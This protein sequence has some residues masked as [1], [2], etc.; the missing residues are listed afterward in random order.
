MANARLIH[1]VAHRGN[2]R[3]CPENTL[4][5][6]RS[7][8]ELGVRFLELDV[9]LA[10]DGIPVV[11]HDHELL[12]TTGR[13]GTVFDHSSAE[14]VQMEAAERT[15]FGERFAGTCI[16]TLGEVLEMVRPRPEVTLFVEI[17]RASLAQH[18]HQ[19]VVDAIATTLGPQRQQCVAISFDLPVLGMLRAQAN[20]AIGWVLS[21]YDA[22]TRL[23]YEALQP[24][25][26]FCNHA[27]LPARESLGPGPWRWVIYEVDN[28]PLALSLAR[29]GAHYIETMAVAPLSAALRGGTVAP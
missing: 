25:F 1:L 17:K 19:R 15:R 18:G 5:A 22:H 29:R 14:L 9:H 24:E 21:S 2:A 11:I 4:P 7:A 16:P 6:F 26:L 13:S 8:L 12:R 23:K 20:L 10:A 3:D 27:R 28:L